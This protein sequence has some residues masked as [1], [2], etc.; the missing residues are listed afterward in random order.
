MTRIDPQDY[1]RRM[2]G[3]T[4]TLAAA[5]RYIGVSRI[6]LYNMLKDG[7]FPVEPIPGTQPR[8][9]NKDDLDA[10]IAGNYAASG[11]AQS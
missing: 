2:N 9:W 11:D 8:R 1:A 4:F 10:W 3:Q 5:S 6:T 7:R